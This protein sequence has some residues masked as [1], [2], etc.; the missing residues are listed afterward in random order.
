MPRDK[1]V[2]HINRKKKL[3]GTSSKTGSPQDPHENVVPL[4]DRAI[5]DLFEPTK[6]QAVDAFNALPPGV[7]ES[8]L[9]MVDAAKGETVEDFLVG[10]VWGFLKGHSRA[11]N[12]FVEKL[13]RLDLLARKSGATEDIQ[14]GVDRAY[15]KMKR[16]KEANED[17]EKPR[18]KT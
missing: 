5:E 3:R 14:K 10:V 17:P 18:G 11:P 15:D 8:V 7:V 13:I 4:R 6:E 16:E 2:V 12:G 1:K 9:S